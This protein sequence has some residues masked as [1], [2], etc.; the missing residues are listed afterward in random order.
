MFKHQQLEHKGEQP[1]FMFKVVSY[2]RT[3]LNGQMKEAVGG[4]EQPVS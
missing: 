1:Q 2:H 4:G 3:A